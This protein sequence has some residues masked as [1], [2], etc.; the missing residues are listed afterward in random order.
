MWF[1]TALML[2]ALFLASWSWLGF[3]HRVTLHRDGFVS[4]KGGRREI[5]RW[6]DI[7]A[8]FQRDVAY[9]INFA[10]MGRFRSF[11]VLRRDGVKLELNDNLTEVARL[12]EAVFQSTLPSLAR[13]AWET[14]SAGGTVSFGPISIH[15]RGL[16]IRQDL[17]PWTEFKGITFSD[18]QAVIQSG[19]RW[20]SPKM[21]VKEI[22]N[23][24]VLLT[25][26]EEIRRQ[27]TE[28]RG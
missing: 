17:V 24:H 7:E 15:Q 12:G 8:V 1:G 20:F 13:K 27:A 22:A 10:P 6:E 5:F 4:D 28:G 21:P 11:T 9:A 23:L 3:R 16:S 19:A 25:L 14:Y 26:I 18:G 2:V